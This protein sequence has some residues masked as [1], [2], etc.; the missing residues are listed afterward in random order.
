MGIEIKKITFEGASGHKLAARLDLPSGKVR[1]YALFAHCFTCSKDIF[2]ASRIARG[3]ADNGIAVLRFDFTGLG[4]SEGEFSNSNFSS[5]IGDLVLAADYLRQN[6]EAPKLLI[7]HSLG[8]AAVLVAASQLPEVTAVGTIGAPAHAGHIAQNFCADI[9]NIER[10]GE[11]PVQL[12]GREFTIQKQF[13]DDLQ[14]QDVLGRIGELRKA[15]MIF[16]APLDQVVGI[17]N[18]AE[19]FMA[20]KHPKSFV[21]LDDADHLLSRRVDAV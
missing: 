4:A 10:H 12:G 5:N 14:E 7:G 15:L 3:L 6:H 20:A 8:G 13:L 17:D 18:A 19:I 21:S 16:H 2:A 9:E 11:A 1:A